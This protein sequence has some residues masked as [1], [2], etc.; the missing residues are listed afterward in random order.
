MK[1]SRF[2]ILV[3]LIVITI[4]F[5]YKL[6]DYRTYQHR[7][8]RGVSLA[9]IYLGGKW[10]AEA[11]ELLGEACSE[12]VKLNYLNHSLLL[13]PQDVGF[14]F[15][16]EEILEE[17]NRLKAQ[18]GFW[19][20]FTDYILSDEPQPVNIPLQAN[21]DE[22]RLKNLL[23][24]IAEEYDR[25][26]QEPYANADTLTFVAGR[27]GQQL[28]IA[29]SLPLVIGA[30]HSATDREVDLVVKVS[31]P[32]REPGLWM[33]G[34]LIEGIMADFPG[35]Y[36]VYIKDLATGE[37]FAD[38]ADVAYSGT[39]ILKIA[40]MVE[41]YKHLDGPPDLDT[42]KILTE[43]MTLSGNYTANLLLR[44]TIGN[45]DAQEGVRQLNET[46]K[47]IGL[48]NTF[49][50][51]PYDTAVLPQH[52][53][54]PANQRTDVNTNPDPFMQ[55]TPQDM[56]RLLEMIY[57]CAKGGGTLIAAYPDELTPD[58]CQAMLDMMSQNRIEALIE[59]GVPEGTRVA[60]KNGWV[61]DSHGDAGIVF[62]PGGDYVLCIYMYRPGWLEW[63]VSSPLMAR[64]SEATYKYFNR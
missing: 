33:M 45:G 13:H 9:G 57:Q 59:A 31:P 3:I 60:H 54:T 53:R 27:P 25:S 61:G 38:D 14:Q 34:Q 7:I 10:E 48:V 51:T 23:T 11:M 43:T 63:D 49:M 44:Y 1:T 29:A 36:S 52:I 50:A 41:A 16:A 40:I 20:G 37:E 42:T 30:L 35:F 22:K 17:V 46:M 18:T 4:A 39:S 19:Q 56:G 24:S 55:T 32:S 12:P 5:F 21:H 8:P 28:D 62:T 47:L 15:K 64:I 58:E 2:M 26:L 6:N